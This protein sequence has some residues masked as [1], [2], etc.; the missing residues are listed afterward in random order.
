MIPYILITRP[1]N[2]LFISVAVLTGA[3][4]NN[5]STNYVVTIIGMVSAMLVGAGGYVIND[6]YDLAIDVI[7]KPK[8]VLPSGKISPQLAYLYAITL[9]VLGFSISFFT[10]SLL[11]IALAISNSIILFLYAKSVKRVLFLN[12]LTVGYTTASAFLYGAIINDNLLNIMPLA[13]FTFLYTITREIVKD[14][15]DMI[16]DKDNKASTLATVFGVKVAV[17]VSFVVAVALG[18]V[19]YLCGARGILQGRLAL[20]L[21]LSF[22][23]P[24]ILIYLLLIKEISVKRL[25]QA[26]QLIKVHMLALLIIFIFVK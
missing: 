22:A 20:V 5:S 15:E 14:A 2:C 21:Q 24:L 23:I 18:V 7:N 1:L 17:I 3:F 19:L 26:S 16:G 25:Y 8:R 13:L 12:N 10:K 4:L 6:F 9:F 11:G